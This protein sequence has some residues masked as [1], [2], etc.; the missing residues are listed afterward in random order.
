MNESM[1]NTNFALSPIFF[2]FLFAWNKSIFEN[3]VSTFIDNLNYAGTTNIKYIGLNQFI[4]S[5]FKS[6][7]ISLGLSLQIE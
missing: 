5:C 2:F 1:F 7:F 3:L 6:K 4:I